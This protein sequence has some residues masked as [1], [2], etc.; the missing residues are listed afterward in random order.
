MRE[1]PAKPATVA[2]APAKVEKEPEAEVWLLRPMNGGGVVV[3]AL[4]A[5]A[6]YLPDEENAV[7]RVSVCFVASGWC[8]VR[9]VVDLS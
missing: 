3:G 8:Q 5:V 4:F 7:G 1:S 9:R 6:R 2:S